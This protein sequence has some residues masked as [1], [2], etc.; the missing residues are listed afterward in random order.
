MIETDVLQHYAPG[1]AA[2]K[3][4]G[5]EGAGSS[6]IDRRYQLEMDR[7]TA[8]SE[9]RILDEAS[10]EYSD[11]LARLEEIEAQMVGL[12]YEKFFYDMNP[13]HHRT[14]V[15]PYDP[16]NNSLNLP[17]RQRSQ[18]LQIVY[19]ERPNLVSY[20][21]NGNSKSGGSTASGTN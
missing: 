18:K 2:D 8:S 12:R 17:T 6:A 14:N 21:G 11:A 19:D 15:R 13:R 1:T 16:I 5:Q 20:A 9:L 3:G 10:S 7:E 4:G